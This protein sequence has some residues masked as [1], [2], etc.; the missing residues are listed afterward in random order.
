MLNLID[1]GL[2][3]ASEMLSFVRE[4]DEKNRE[5]SQRNHEEMIAMKSNIIS[6]IEQSRVLLV[7]ETR[8][9]TEQVI[10][11]IELE[12]LEKLKSTIETMRLALELENTSL[13]DSTLAT[14]LPLS[15]YALVRLN[16]GKREWLLP[17]IHSCSICLVGLSL[18]AS[19]ENAHTILQRENQ[20]FRIEILNQLKNTLLQ[21]DVPWLKISSFVNGDDESILKSLVGKVE[22][23]DSVKLSFDSLS[24]KLGITER[25]D[26]TINE[27]YIEKVYLKASSDIVT[28]QVIMLVT[29]E[30]DK[31]TMEAEIEAT[32]SGI[33]KEIYVKNGDKV[34]DGANLYTIFST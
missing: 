5:I 24:V 26:L 31:V 8:A 6:A 30:T 34:K 33:L 1:K 7:E 22:Q 9:L 20:N 28:G 4:S 14:L 32:K 11:K 16:E 27:V 21:N 23:Q 13:I 2:E 15:K 25:E 12:Q 10:D 17:W 18:N 19:T 3:I 29:I